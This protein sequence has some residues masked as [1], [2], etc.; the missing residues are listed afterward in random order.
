M[1]LPT[2]ITVARILLIPVFVV[3]FLVPMPYGKIVSAA[4][5]VLASLSDWLDGYLA[6]KNNQVTNIGKFLD[7]IADK[8]LVTCALVLV[9]IMGIGNDALAAAVP[10]NYIFTV[11]FA[12]FT[13]VILS[14]ELMVSGLRIIASS[15]NVIMAADKL[16]KAKTAT[17][18][19]AL[20][21][22]LPVVDIV[23]LSGTVGAYIYY[24]GFG[25]LSIATLLTVVSGINY[26][27]KNKGVLKDE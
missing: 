16:G 7:P 14:R 8:M 15:K 11:C 18:M 20:I 25:L 13:M 27:V 3:F 19:V 5:F 4:V 21:L 12:V 6:R 17:Q 9:I 2:K 23:A 10:H 22:L 1:N 26:L 24:I